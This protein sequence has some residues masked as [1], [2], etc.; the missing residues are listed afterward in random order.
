[1]R[2]VRQSVY[3]YLLGINFLKAGKNLTMKSPAQCG[4][5]LM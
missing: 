5:F 3:L 4:N 2:D 1:M